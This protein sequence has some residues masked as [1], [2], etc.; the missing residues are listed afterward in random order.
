MI[1]THDPYSKAFQLIKRFRR[2]GRCSPLHLMIH[3]KV[4]YKAAEDL[5]AYYDLMH[6]PE[7]EVYHIVNFP[8]PDKK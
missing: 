2:T 3:C 7:E 8:Y 5:L 6:T 4:T 1:D